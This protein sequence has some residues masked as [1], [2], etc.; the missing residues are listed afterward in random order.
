MKSIGTIYV[1][2]AVVGGYGLFALAALYAMAGARGLAAV[3]L[4]AVVG[5]ILHGSIGGFIVLG[6][7]LWLAE[8]LLRRPEMLAPRSAASRVHV[9]GE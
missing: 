4:S 7:S 2:G 3:A 5:M 6:M 9:S 8:R 1:I